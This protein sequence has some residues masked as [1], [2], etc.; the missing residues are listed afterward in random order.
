M[1]DGITDWTNR[2][3]LVNDYWT[4]PKDIPE[5]RVQMLKLIVEELEMNPTATIMDCGCG[6]G[7]TFKYLPDEYKDRYYGVDFTQEMVDYC[8]ENYPE[9]IK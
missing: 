8:K 7:L 4:A 3:K 6:T 2:A 9:Y 1:K 5:Y